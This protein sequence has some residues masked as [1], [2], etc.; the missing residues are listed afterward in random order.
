MHSVHPDA[1]AHEDHEV[2]SLAIDTADPY[3]PCR[4]YGDRYATSCWLFQG[5]VIL[6]ATGFDAGRALRVCDGAPRGRAARCYEGIGHQLTGLFQRGDRWILDQCARGHAGL[7]RYCA[8]GAALAVDAMDWS[9][10]RAAHLCAAAPEEW[11]ETCYRSASEALVDLAP[12]AQRARLCA[13]VE[14]A[15]IGSCREA[16]DLVRPRPN[17]APAPLGRDRAPSRSGIRIGRG[18]VE[19]NR[20]VIEHV[21]DA[22]PQHQQDGDESHRDQRDDQGVLHEPLTGIVAPECL[23]QR[24][25][26][27]LSGLGPASSEQRPPGRARAL[28]HS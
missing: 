6:R 9:G 3:S 7:A 18:V 28:G 21:A 19:L 14:P 2:R 27:D 20:S 25:H 10:F 26:G 13:A 23:P 4:A 5:F 11:K 24:L 16:G 12:P 15:H 1:E 22:V 17:G 8:A